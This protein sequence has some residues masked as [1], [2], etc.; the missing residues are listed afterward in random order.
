MNTFQRPGIPII[1]E[2]QDA[3]T[4]RPYDVVCLALFIVYSLLGKQEM[5]LCT[6]VLMDGDWNKI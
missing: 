2:C 1:V 6:R 4:L 3:T 5:I